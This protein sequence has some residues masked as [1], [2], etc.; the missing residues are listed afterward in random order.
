MTTTAQIRALISARPKRAVGH[1]GG[2]SSTIVAERAIE[3]GQ[4]TCPRIRSREK[5]T[6]LLRHLVVE[7][8]WGAPGGEGRVTCRAVVWNEARLR[9]CAKWSLPEGNVVWMV[10]AEGVEPSQAF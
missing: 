3:D 1:K 10:R 4:V 8:G 6:T 7:P 9:E 2:N 5:T